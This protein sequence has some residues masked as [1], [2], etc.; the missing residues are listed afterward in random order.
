MLNALAKGMRSFIA[1]VGCS[2]GRERDNVTV[3]DSEMRR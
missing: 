2:G 1:V 3:D